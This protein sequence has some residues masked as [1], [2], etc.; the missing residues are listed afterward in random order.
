M[1]MTLQQMLVQQ[2]HWTS[3][4]TG[5]TIYLWS[6]VSPNR[7][8]TWLCKEFG[9]EQADPSWTGIQR[10][11][12]YE[13]YAGSY[14]NMTSGEVGF[15]GGGNSWAASAVGGVE[16][17]RNANVD[18]SLCVLTVPAGTT[19]VFIVG[20]PQ[21]S[22]GGTATVTASGGTVEAASLDSRSIT[23]D[24]GKLRSNF[25]LPHRECFVLIASGNLG[26]ETITITPDND[27]FF[28]LGFIC[29]NDN[30]RA[31][32]DDGVFDP[33]SAIH[34]N[35]Q[36][37]IGP[38][39]MNI[40]AGA[41]ANGFWGEDH[42]NDAGGD[43]HTI[44]GVAESFLYNEE[45]AWVMTDFTQDKQQVVNTFRRILTGTIKIGT[46]GN[47]T[48][49]GDYEIQYLFDPSGYTI[50]AKATW[51]AAAAPGD[52][53]VFLN[54]ALNGAGGYCAQWGLESSF[55]EVRRIPLDV[56]YTVVDTYDDSS[57]LA[58]NCA[59]MQAR[60]GNIVVTNTSWSSLGGGTKRLKKVSAG[61]GKIYHEG[62]DDGN[63]DHAVADGEV[64]EYGQRRTI[65]YEDAVE[66]PGMSG[67][68]LASR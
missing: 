50:I 38:C 56:N 46:T 45:T 42:W 5:P 7:P 11:T 13:M 29:I 8:Y 1:A 37:Q 21:S 25:Q 14:I 33:A 10:E 53:A 28:A 44:T 57:I 55:N 32:P 54:D 68:I 67:A 23:G 24:F 4:S 36:G 40:G 16:R 6:P 65:T 30:V 64:T 34:I 3:G 62:F 66:T 47:E 31:T 61:Y 58:A 41:V 18:S 59:T 2:I 35:T 12:V 9:E 15:P 49:V 60:S 39:P 26:G 63:G 19:R 20:Y 22:S 27:R 52:V 17:W 48:D 51:N 43:N